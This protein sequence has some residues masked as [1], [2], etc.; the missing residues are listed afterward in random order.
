MIEQ[1]VDGY[2]SQIADPSTYQS[3]LA[4]NAALAGLF[5]PM[6]QLDDARYVPDFT[7]RYLTEDVPHGLVAMKGVAELMD[8]PTPHFDKIIEWAQDK[9]VCLGCHWLIYRHLLT[10]QGVCRWWEVDWQ[11]R[12]VGCVPAGIWSHHARGVFGGAAAP[13]RERGRRGGYVGPG[14]LQGQ[15]WGGGRVESV[16]SPSHRAL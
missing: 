12:G 7:Y 16:T 15:S 14:A 6:K 9:M 2:G 1:M 10:G 11:R 5:H 13:A 3:M 4:T 8:V